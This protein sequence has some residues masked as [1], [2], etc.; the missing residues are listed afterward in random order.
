MALCDA[1]ILFVSAQ[2]T[3]QFVIVGNFAWFVWF[4]V[5]WCGRCSGV[6]SEKW[7]IDL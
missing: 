3:L 6:I 2:N 4:R 5:C 7:T 1:L